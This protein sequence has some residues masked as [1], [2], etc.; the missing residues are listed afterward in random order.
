M[1]EDYHLDKI[2]K[3]SIVNISDLAL[4]DLLICP[5]D[6]KICIKSVLCTICEKMF[7]IDCSLM[8]NTCYNEYEAHLIDTNY[9]ICL[10]EINKIVINCPLNCNCLI[11]FTLMKSHLTVCLENIFNCPKCLLQIKN[12]NMLKHLISNCNETM[13]DCYLCKTK[14]SIE[15]LLNNH[16]LNCNKDNYNTKHETDNDLIINQCKNCSLPFLVKK[17]STIGHKHV[18]ID[19][20]DQNNAKA[21]QFHLK[22]INDTLHLLLNENSSIRKDDNNERLIFKE[23]LFQ[24]ISE[25]E[26][27]INES[28][29]LFNTIHNNYIHRLDL[30]RIKRIEDKI[31]EIRIKEGDLKIKDDTIT[32]LKYQ[33]K[34]Y[35]H[36]NSFNDDKERIAFMMRNALY[37]NQSYKELIAKQKNALHFNQCDRILNQSPLIKYTNENTNDINNVINPISNQS[38]GSLMKCAICLESLNDKELYK[39]FNKECSN[40]LCLNCFSINKHQ[41]RQDNNASCSFF[42]CEQ[43]LDKELICVMNTV[44]CLKCEARTCSQCYRLKHK[45]H[46][47]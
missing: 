47:I 25:I 34:Y 21:I 32:E 33:I 27:I 10:S 31:E 9:T 16:L 18:C 40:S 5:I 2:S 45:E 7:C 37:I 1:I 23:S 14:V 38:N 36:L 3:D 17:N 44:L 22:Q 19:I 43:C 46:D 29:C 11:P 39:C 42:Q 8:H 30:N 35:T 12:K 13:I 15:L 20:N 28:I 26:K 41:I 24:S 4:I 6:S